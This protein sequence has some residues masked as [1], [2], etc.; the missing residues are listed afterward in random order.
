[1]KR[2]KR[3]A[4]DINNDVSEG[5]EITHEE[6]LQLIEHLNDKLDDMHNGRRAELHHI[7]CYCL[8]AMGGKNRGEELKR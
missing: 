1:M 4:E 8:N 7:M 3:K 5:I 6:A 2:K